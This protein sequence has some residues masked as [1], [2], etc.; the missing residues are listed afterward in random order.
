MLN[1][2]A[3]LHVLLPVSASEP[4]PC[5]QKRQPHLGRSW[6]AWAH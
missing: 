3:R 1:A 2:Y 4:L 5:H 6:P